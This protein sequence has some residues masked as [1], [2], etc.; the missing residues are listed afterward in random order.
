MCAAFSLFDSARNSEGTAD[1]VR[2]YV[3][4]KDLA[5]MIH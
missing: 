1:M 5:S 2:M 3:G 4:S